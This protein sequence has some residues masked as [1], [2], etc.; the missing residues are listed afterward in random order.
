[1]DFK[2]KPFK[3][4]RKIFEKACDMKAYGLFWEPGTGKSKTLIDLMRYKFKKYGE[5]KTLILCPKIVQDSW[6]KQLGIHSYMDDLA[7]VVSGDRERKIDL[8]NNKKPIKII[9]YD[10]LNVEE[11]AEYIMS[12]EWMIKV[13]DESHRIKNHKSGRGKMATQIPSEF[14][15]IASG[16]PI[17]RNE[18]DLYNQIKFLGSKILGSNFYSYRGRYFIDENIRFKGKKEYWPN[19][20][21]DPDKKEELIRKLSTI[22]DRKTKEECLDL[23]GIMYN[24]IQVGMSKEQA[25]AYNNIQAELIHY[26]KKTRD[27]EV[28]VAKNILTKTIRL[29]QIS[30]GFMKTES[31]RII[32]FKK[33]PKLEAV[34]D[35]VEDYDKVIISCAFIED[36]ETIGKHFKN[37]AYLYG[38]KNTMRDFTEGSAR[39]LIAHPHVMIG[40][41]E[42]VMTNNVVTYSR[43]YSYEDRHQSIDRVYRQGQ[44][45]KVSVTDFVSSEMDELVL[46][47]L[48]NKQN[49]AHGILAHLRK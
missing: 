12:E 28:V 18:L 3:H 40:I 21:I 46:D 10:A 33:N 48:D 22:S 27:P 34:M 47:N 9:N 7:Q 17:L 36:I 16:T 45:K 13:A 38:A 4:Q 35:F 19:F 24:K 1:M 30:S 43:N 37:P 29:L 26:V 2:T 49:I 5:G 23:P 39:V 44:I 20:V 31:G 11:I 14:S 6:V 8:L 25:E 42:L 32:P 41:N 15:Y